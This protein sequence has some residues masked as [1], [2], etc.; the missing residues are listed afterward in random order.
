MCMA[1]W[2]VASQLPPAGWLA[3]LCPRECETWL[4]H[5]VVLLP[6]LEQLAITVF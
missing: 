5:A 1:L 3:V 4:H 2:Q 6:D